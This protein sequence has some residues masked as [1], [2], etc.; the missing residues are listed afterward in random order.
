MEKVIRYH[1]QAFL[2][3]IFTWLELS[4]PLYIVVAVDI[5]IH[6]SLTEKL[7]NASK[8][9]AIDITNILP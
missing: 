6:G 5:A 4:C 8:K 2:Y 3:I 9:E 1:L 7:E